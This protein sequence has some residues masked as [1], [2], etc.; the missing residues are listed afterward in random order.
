MKTTAIYWYRNRDEEFRK[1]FTRNDQHSIVY[2]KHVSGLVVVSGLEYNASEWRSTLNSFV[3][4]MKAVLQ[5]IG[6]KVAS[7][8]IAHSV[9]FKE[10]YL[11]M[12]YLLEALC[13]NLQQ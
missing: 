6:N 7:V 12:N 2:C 13:Y 3:R 11:D 1:H 8:P 10:F 9:V 5:H 4:S